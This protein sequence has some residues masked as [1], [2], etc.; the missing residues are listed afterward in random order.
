MLLARRSF[1]LGSLALAGCARVPVAPEGP[2]APITLEDAFAGRSRGAGVFRVPITGTERR[3][4]A[5]LDGRLEGDRLTV[6]EDFTYD[7]G[8]ENTLTWV[9]DRA[10]DVNG[11]RRWTGTRDDTVG[12]ATVREL[13]T[14]I[15]LSYVVDFESAG[16]VTR[17]GFEDVIY[18][19]EDGRVIND[20][21]VTRWG[22][23]VGTVRFELLRAAG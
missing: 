16:S 19:G 11:E 22:I 21:I 6:V 23:P 14:E 17:L 2:R 13:G 9:F 4:R 8:E 12:T 18:F 1:V 3:F 15:R 5:D 20:A 10:P 7:D